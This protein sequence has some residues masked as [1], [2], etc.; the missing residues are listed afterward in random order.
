MSATKLGHH[1]DIRRCLDD[2]EMESSAIDHMGG[3]ANRPSSRNGIICGC[4]REAGAA[5][6]F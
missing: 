6:L 3:G 4:D 1:L 2:F 5:G